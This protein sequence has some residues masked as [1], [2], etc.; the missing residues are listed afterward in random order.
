MLELYTLQWS[1]PT[2][3]LPQALAEKMVR[4]NPPRLTPRESVVHFHT[5]YQTTQLNPLLVERHA[6]TA[7]AA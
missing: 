7:S 1:L 5:N 6:Q 3:L 2:V 4:V